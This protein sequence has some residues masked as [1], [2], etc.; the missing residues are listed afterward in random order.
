M[1][2]EVESTCFVWHLV[3]DGGSCLQDLTWQDIESLFKGFEVLLIDDGEQ[4][5]AEGEEVGSIFFLER[6]ALRIQGNPSPFYPGSFFG[7][8]QVLTG[9]AATKAVIAD[10]PARLLEL[11]M[12]AAEEAMG[13]PFK[14][15]IQ[16]RKQP[17][18]S[19]PQIDFKVIFF[20]NIT[21]PH[22]LVIHTCL[23]LIIR[24][25]KGSFLRLWD[26]ANIH[27]GF[28]D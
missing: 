10:G 2:P 4:L 16:N 1:L 3:S 5:I 21:D 25:V 13:C 14:E 23:H 19:V 9:R 7:V 8:D 20:A 15:L 17:G 12:E 28:R 27:L 24:T 11:S 26:Q 18:S 22:L 6:G